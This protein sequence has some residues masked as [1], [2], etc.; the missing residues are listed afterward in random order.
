MASVPAPL[1]RYF[2]KKKV[3]N[4]VIAGAY[5]HLKQKGRSNSTKST[6]VFLLIEEHT[7][8]HV[9]LKFSSWSSGLS[10]H[11]LKCSHPDHLCTTQVSIYTHETTTPFAPGG[12]QT[13]EWTGMEW[14]TGM[15]C[16]VQIPVVVFQI[17]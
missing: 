11:T 13:L 4:I 10:T 7:S 14:T 8:C 15:A 9:M 1:A 2:T 3:M 12:V 16:K 17:E 6:P 5:H